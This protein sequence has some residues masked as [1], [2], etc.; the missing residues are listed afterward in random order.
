MSNKLLTQ[1]DFESAAKE[2]KCEVAAIKAVAEVEA[3]RGGFLPS[4]RPVILFEA[5][6]FSNKTNHK[7]DASHPHIS[8]KTWN[9]KLYLGGEK[10]YSRLEEAMKLDEMA[11]LESTSWGKFQIMGFNYKICG[12]NN[13]KD[14]VNDMYISES[15][16]LKAFVSFIKYSKLDKHLINKNW[17]AFA[18]AYNGPAYEKNKY[19]IKLESAYKKYKEQENKNNLTT[20]ESI[21]ITENIEDK[22]T[23]NLEN[24]EQPTV[25][26]N[27]LHVEIKNDNKSIP[28]ENVNSN[29]KKEKISFISILIKI[30][31]FFNK[32]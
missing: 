31:N 17:K 5:H 8:S 12:W 7:Y 16:H 1:K 19:D 13:V 18:R 25:L 4:G 26:Q 23:I 11:A 32:K 24:I 21:N 20:E 9:R 30:I 2:L 15:Y 28:V 14:F 10:E 29:V 27:N 22:N 6:I 3:P